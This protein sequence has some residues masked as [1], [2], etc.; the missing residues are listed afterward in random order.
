MPRRFT[1]YTRHKDFHMSNDRL[2]IYSTLHQAVNVWKANT[3]QQHVHFHDIV[4]FMEFINEPL[5]GRNYLDV[6]QTNPETY[7]LVKLIAGSNGHVIVAIIKA[8]REH[9][10]SGCAGNNIS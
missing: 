5:N 10:K 1:R 4:K 3:Q 7:E 9:G 6:L 8:R 2:Q